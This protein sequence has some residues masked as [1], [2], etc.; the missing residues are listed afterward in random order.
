[1]SQPS[2][3]IRN[4]TIIDG[5]GRNGYEADLAIA[6]GRISAIGQNLPKGAEEIDAS[7]KLVTPGFV[8][9]HTHYDAQ[10]TWSERLS[11]STWNGVTT[12]LLGNCGV[13]FAPCHAD[14]RDLLA[15]YVDR[16]FEVLPSVWRDRTN[17]IAQTITMG[18]YPSLLASQELLDKTDAF[19]AEQAD[20]GRR[21]EDAGLVFVGPT[22]DQL[23][24]LKLWIEQGAKGEVR[25]LATVNWLEKPPILDPILALDLSRDGKLIATASADKTAKLDPRIRSKAVQAAKALDEEVARL[26]LDHL[27]V[28]APVRGDSI[29]NGAM[30]NA[31]GIAALLALGALQGDLGRS[32]VFNEPALK[33]IAAR[34][35]ATLELARRMRPL[36]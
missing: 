20:F 3:V 21:C 18:F 32:F 4:G 15:A 8:D 19:L 27:G 6:D 28:G 34:M 36:L 30:D 5:S 9:V 12:V 24:L 16:Y 25:G 29:Y 1:M 7:G 10:V 33:L 13:G 14:Q 2:L 31:S 26:H 11:P 17:E 23:A 22:P 35:P